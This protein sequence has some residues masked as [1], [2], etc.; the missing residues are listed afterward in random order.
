M[1]INFKKIFTYRTVENLIFLLIW[2]VIFTIPLFRNKVYESIL[3]D[4]V[5]ADWLKISMFLAVFL[6]NIFLLIP[7]YLLRK[8]HIDYIL[9][10]IV[11]ASLIV[12][13]GQ[14]FQNSFKHETIS[15]M[16]PMEIGPGLPPM[17]FSEDMPPPETYKSLINEKK[18]NV[19]L[20]FMI[21]LAI[22]VLVI[23]TGTAYKVLILWIREEKRRKHLEE[24]MT[25][26]EQK[27]EFIFVKSD[28]KMVKIK[29]SDITHI[30]SANEYI[31]IY[32]ENSDTITTF[33]RLKNIESK[34]PTDKFMRVQRSF[35]VNLEK[36]KAIEKNRIYLEPKKFIPIG[37]Q[38][39]EAFQ[40][41]LGKKFIN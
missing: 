33:M 18:P 3:W 14:S 41:F 5:Y 2:L 37:E 27:E 20:S 17:E 30:E 4:D 40:D 24:T 6:I 39:K 35:I 34:L 13:A 32:L 9:A 12:C 31:K 19:D 21:N 26:A 10:A 1:L 23:G 25:P 15:E 7:H 16:P 38:Y 28:Y 36:I 8:L 29:M 11:M 22:A